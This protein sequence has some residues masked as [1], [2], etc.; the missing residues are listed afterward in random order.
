M[1]F[2]KTEIDGLVIIEPKVF[3][4][5]R[6]YFFESF[7]QKRFQ[8]NVRE[9]E[10]VQDNE[11]RSSYGVLRGLHFQKPP[12]DQAKLVRC[13]EGKVLDVAVDI[14]KGSP[15]FGKHISVELSD[16]NK[17]QFFVP[18]GFAHGFVVLSKSAIFQY[19]VDN[20]YA[21]DYDAGIAWNDKELGIDWK[22]SYE[23]I[24]LSE[25]DKGLK[26]LAETEI[27]FT[28]S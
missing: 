2:I 15:T 17:R 9:I 8:E 12:F 23:S 27:P 16:E 3:G 22:M 6:G 13:I 24:L 11:S 4:D 18:R 14:R 20:W 7:N 25:K 19:K 28:F 10:F 21:P 5:P 26:N 1:Q